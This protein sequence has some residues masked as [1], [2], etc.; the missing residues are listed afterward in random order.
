[1]EVRLTNIPTRRKRV[2]LTASTAIA[3]LLVACAGAR[4]GSAANDPDRQEWID[5][6][7]GKNLDGWTAKIAKH[8]VGENFGNTF[9]VV[10]GVIQARYDGYGGNYNAQFGHLY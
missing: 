6:F 2:L 9:R 1:M 5:L 10:D 8:E 3:V 4:M 7:N